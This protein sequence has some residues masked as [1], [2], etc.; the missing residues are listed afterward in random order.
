VF[1]AGTQGYKV[2]EIL[3]SPGIQKLFLLPLRRS[4]SLRSMAVAALHWFCLL[5]QLLLAELL[6]LS[7]AGITDRMQCQPQK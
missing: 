4:V 2:Q 1:V 3:R 7:G 5:V 6:P